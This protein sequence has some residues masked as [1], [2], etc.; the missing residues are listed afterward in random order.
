MQDEQQDVPLGGEAEELEAVE[1]LALQVEGAQAHL[2]QAAGE[3]GLVL[4][5]HLHG[6][7]RGGHL[8]EGELGALVLD[9]EGGAQ[10]RV[11]REQ[12]LEGL[13]RAAASTGPW[14]STARGML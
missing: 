3:Q 8:V 10:G 12:L 7:H 4:A 1:G 6:Q 2:A 9:G 14:S 13:S 5:Q 11:P